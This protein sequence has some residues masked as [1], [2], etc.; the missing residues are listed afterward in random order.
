MRVFLQSVVT[1]LLSTLVPMSIL[2]TSGS[3]QSLLD[4]T[5]TL[6]P[7]GTT[8]LPAFNDVMV[9][10]AT[11][12]QGRVYAGGNFLRLKTGTTTKDIALFN[13]DGSI[14]T[15]FQ[16]KPNQLL[17]RNGEVAGIYS[18]APRKDGSVY[19]S[20][21]FSS[22]GYSSKYQAAKLRADGR[23][24][25]D[26]LRSFYFDLPGWIIPVS[27]MPLDD[28]NVLAWGAFTDFYLF[29]QPGIAMA[30]SMGRGVSTFRPLLT[31]NSTFGEFGYEVATVARQ[32][33]GKFVFGGVFTS[34]EAL[35]RKGLARIDGTGNIDAGF[36]PYLNFSVVTAVAL[37]PDGDVMVA[38]TIDGT[39]T[40]V[41]ARMNS[42]GTAHAGFTQSTTGWIGSIIPR[43]DGRFL[44]VGDFAAVGA[45][46]RT[47]IAI[48]EDNGAVSSI[49]GTE[50]TDGYVNAAVIQ[51]DGKVIVGGEFQ[52]ISG[53]ARNSLARLQADAPVAQDITIDVDGTT[54]VWNRSG[55]LPEVVDM[56]FEQSTNGGSS[57]TKLGNGVRNGTNWELTGQS[58]PGG[59]DVLIRAIGRFSSGRFNSST[60]LI[61]SRLTVNRPLPVITDEPDSQTVIVG[62]TGISFS[63]A[64][65]SAA[66]ITNY[67]WRRNGVNIPGASGPALTTYTLPNP[68]TTA[69]AG[70]YTVVV[71]STA[72]S[73]TSAGAVLTV[74]TPI[75]ITKQPVNVDVALGKTATFSVTVT[76]T[77]PQY[78][79]YRGMNLIGTNKSTLTIPNAQFINE[80]NDYH[81]VVS[82]FAGS[83]PSNMVSL[84]VVVAP[85]VSMPPAH[86]LVGVGN[87]ATFNAMLTIESPRSFAWLKNAKQVTT[88]PAPSL[89]IPSTQ[90]AD[91]GKY[92]LKATNAAGSVTTSPPAELGVV[93]VLN[94]TKVVV[95]E[96]LTAVLKA[97][98]AGN[99]LI[100]TWRLGMT[101]ITASPP[102]ITLSA[103]GRTLTIRQ[104]SLSTDAGAYVVDVTGPPGP[105]PMLTSAP[106]NLVITTTAPEIDDMALNLPDGM[107][108]APYDG[109]G[110]PGAPFVPYQI[111][112]VSNPLQ[113]A[114]RYSASPLPPG[115]KLDTAT[116]KI[117]G[118][119]TKAGD[120]TVKIKAFNANGASEEKSDTIHI[121]PVPTDFLGSYQALVSRT[122]LGDQHGGQVDLTVT[123]AGSYSGKVTLGTTVYQISGGDLQVGVGYN[124]LN[125]VLAKKTG[126][127]SLTLTFSINTMTNLLTGSVTDGTSSATVD[128]WRNKWSIATP[129]T[130]YEGLFNF[131]MTPP[132]LPP[133]DFTH[134]TGFSY[135]S[136]KPSA[137]TGKL[138]VAGRLADGTSF[139]SAG[140]LGPEGEV[141]FYKGF[142]TITSVQGLLD[143]APVGVAPA[144]LD[145]S[146]NGTATWLRKPQTSASIRSYAAGFNTISM[147]AA[148]FEY[149]PPVS[150]Q[151]ALD[152]STTDILVSLTFT[153]G[154]DVTTVPDTGAMMNTAQKVTPVAPNNGKVSLTVTASTG[155]VSGSFK[156]T[157]GS[158]TRTA[159]FYGL[160]IRQGTM[161]GKAY[162]FFNL[163]RL[164]PPT[165]SPQISGKFQMEK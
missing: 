137:T 45:T 117:S 67:Q 87:P 51:A 33:D 145:S 99:G 102:R 128:G 21:L 15:A 92:T 40:R 18:I 47:D 88:T 152:L 14:V 46:A 153:E 5:F 68:V 106:V 157:D 147:A 116:G 97:P 110:T 98:V 61:S 11:D 78:Q 164:P 113:T 32:A 22:I 127:P 28:G 101:T 86:Q 59:K 48:I 121:D 23:A 8:G 16:P 134:P 43:V 105:A 1:F 31:S 20:G 53:T 123:S 75:S 119:P 109:D 124:S 143:I 165:L 36:V 93:D 133:N 114:T 19:V 57:Y 146:V 149:T 142:T 79:W 131:R 115:L 85:T 120:W 118:T 69:D 96:G 162:G 91:A 9:S 26:I 35:P 138:T 71:T 56:F 129:A 41:L 58:I 38:G 154:A 72:G 70:T 12:V 140:L 4:T 90:L 141:A 108:G 7:Q 34:V 107:V 148:G 25:L 160:I 135:G 130:D 6:E 111:P 163:Y 159:P 81:V 27:I 161:T 30:D 37:L 132:V 63:V 24:E 65:T 83:V 122:A 80:A 62:N 44:V 100:V 139:S 49:Y 3:A 55:P 151:N 10:L 29:D 73:K 158:S 84:D 125:T 74:I 94:P 2:P 54:L 103:D 52:N 76:G 136:F 17:S 64:A 66:T 155:L 39:T 95:G 82:N 156:Q 89:T 42:D 144:Y 104:A 13:P 126:K 150:G 50:S 77:S 112:T 60:S